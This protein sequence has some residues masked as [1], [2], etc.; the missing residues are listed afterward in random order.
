MARAKRA[1]RKSAKRRSIQ[2]RVRSKEGDPMG[3]G[4][5]LRERS[6][7]SGLTFPRVCFNC[8]YT[9]SRPAD[10][11]PRCGYDTAR[12]SQEHGFH[13]VYPDSGEAYLTYADLLDA[14]LSNR[15]PEHPVRIAVRL[16]RQRGA[17]DRAQRITV[18]AWNLATLDTA[19]RESGRSDAIAELMERVRSELGQEADV[20][21]PLLSRTDIFESELLMPAN[22]GI[23]DVTSW[24]PRTCL[25]CRTEGH[26]A[27]TRC[28][29]CGPMSGNGP[30]F[31]TRHG[32]I[33]RTDDGYVFRDHDE[34]LDEYVGP[35]TSIRATHPWRRALYEAMRRDDHLTAHNLC[36]HAGRITRGEGDPVESLRRLNEIAHAELG[37]E[38]AEPLSDLPGEGDNV[39]F[40][41]APKGVSE[42]HFRTGC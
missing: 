7:K 12:N 39:L 8:G 16:A 22:S 24:L 20:F 33:Y 34:A 35:E 29:K 19:G 18:L 13:L 3:N 11:C 14:S 41:L 17:L 2:S 4:T 23:P 30:V 21:G 27:M 25:R 37:G 9:V 38:G 6:H 15:D 36:Y 32:V 42:V 26:W 28:P 31:A 1:Q 40:I 5:N 10:Q